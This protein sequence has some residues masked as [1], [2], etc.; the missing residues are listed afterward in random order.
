M[1]A[2][3][4]FLLDKLDLKPVAVNKVSAGDIEQVPSWMAASS[5]ARAECAV[6]NDGA[7]AVVG[8]ACRFPGGATNPTAFWAMLRGGG[9]GVVENPGGTMAC[10]ED[11]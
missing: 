7:L 6:T 2:L 1:N 5:R 3:A 4:D 8:M 11:L 10:S 9:D